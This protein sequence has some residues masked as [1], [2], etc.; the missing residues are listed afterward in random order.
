MSLY[1]IL[2]LHKMQHAKTTV[3]V[4]PVG[5]SGR[6]RVFG[7][8]IE[9]NAAYEYDF[10]VADDGTMLPEGTAYEDFGSFFEQTTESATDVYPQ[11]YGSLWVLVDQP[12][13]GE[14]TQS[15]YRI[16][17]AYAV[18]QASYFGSI[19]SG[20]DYF[21]VE[22]KNL[23][24]TAFR[25]RRSMLGIATPDPDPF[26]DRVVGDYALLS[27]EIAAWQQWIIDNCGGFFDLSAGIND[28]KTF[29]QSAAVEGMDVWEFCCKNRLSFFDPADES[30]WGFSY[31]TQ[32]DVDGY[33]LLEWPSSNRVAMDG[34]Y[35]TLEQLEE[36]GS[37]LNLF[38]MILLPAIKWRL[39]PAYEFDNVK[40]YGAQDENFG[41][42]LS[43]LE[44]YDS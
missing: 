5:S 9:F 11:V 35:A 34:D 17:D 33:P 36:I 16:D 38:D 23:I 39:D 43:G 2:Y 44:E 4:L 1:T 7:F 3:P 31:S 8:P 41:A 15:G 29:A 26:A 21:R 19:N 37:C 18:F 10:S 27:S 32:Q 13:I 42:A 22:K 20:L 12:G 24:H 28:P 40:Y 14:I 30:S 25:L 6:V